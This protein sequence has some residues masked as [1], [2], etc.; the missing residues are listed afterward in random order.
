MVNYLLLRKL[1]AYG[2]KS[3][4][5][6][7]ELE[8]GPGITVVVG[9]NGSGKSN[10]SDAIR[11]A[12]GEQSVRNLRGAKLEDVIFA[13]STGRRPLGVAEVSLVFDNSDGGLPL[14]FN[15]VIITRR[16]FRSGDSEYFINKARC[17]LKDIYDLLSDTGLGRDA[18]PVI[19]QN[20]IDEVLNSKAEER[21]L[22]FEEAAGI[23]KYKQRKKEASRKLEDTAQ[24]LTR[25]SDITSE[26]ENQLEPLAESAARTARYNDLHKELTAYQV[27]LLMDKL[28]RAEK[29]VESANLQQQALADD[30]IAVNTQ[31]TLHETEL[32]RLNGQLDDINEKIT[33]AEAGSNKA[34]TDL[35][36]TDGKIGVLEE[37][38]KQ[39]ENTGERIAG[40]ICQAEARQAEVQNKASDLQNELEDKKR[41]ASTAHKELEVKIVEYQK[42]LT[43][44]Q[45]I[46]QQ[47][48][49][50]KDKTFAQL[51]E[52]VSERNK[53]STS[54]RD[55]A[56]LKMRQMNFDKE[57]QDYGRQLGEAELQYNNILEEKKTIQEVLIEL[58][59]KNETLLE[60]NKHVE[61]SLDNL[62]IE[63]KQL[64]NQLNE[65]TS[66]LNVLSGM[67]QELEGFS[68]GIKSILNSNKE[69]RQGI[70]GAVAQIITVPDKY[71]TAVEVALGGALQHIIT[72]D[73]QIA[74]NAIEF[75]KTQNLGRATFLPLNTIKVNRPRESEI[76]A[77]ATQGALG[78]ASQLVSCQERFRNVVDFLLGRTIVAEN[79]DV[80]LKIAKQNS[81]GI[82]LVT[83]E[84]EIV[85]PGGSM[86]GGSTARREAS[87]ISRTNE[88]AAGKRTID[89][90]QD[91][92][93]SHKKLRDNVEADLANIQQDLL[94]INQE[95]QSAQ[96]R[97]AELAVHAEKLQ[98][99]INRLTLATHTLT[100]EIAVAHQEQELLEKALS[101]LKTNITVLEERDND[102]KQ[103]I[104]KSQQQAKELQKNKDLLNDAVTEAKIVITALNQEITAITANSERYKQDEQQIHV[105]LKNL[106]AE[107][108]N[109]VAQ[110]ALSDQELQEL[111]I[112]RDKL[113]EEKLR[114]GEE[115]KTAY[116]EKMLLLS[117]IQKLEKEL[118]ELRRKY[119]DIQS[120]LHEAELISAKYG[121]EV[122]GC[123]EQLQ[124]QFDL[125]RE[126]AKDI[127]HPVSYEK[128]ATV[129]KRLED[130][131]AL[132]GPVNAIAIEEYA[133]VQERYQFL[134]QQYQ[135]L[136][137]ARDYLTSI[138]NDIDNNMS[139]QFAVAFKSIN[140]HFG[141]IFVRL[142]GGG[143]AQLQLI[144][145]D[146]VL[147]TGIDIIVQPPGKK[148]QNLILLSGGERALTVIALLFAFLT[149]RPVPFTMVDEI[150]AALDEANI[151]RFSEFLRDYAQNTQ[152]IVVTH[153]KAT[154]EV[155]DVLHGVTMEESGVSR[156]VSVKFMDKVG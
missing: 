15:E 154:M 93:S 18:M 116:A 34:S 105:Y 148:Q 141:D 31:T 63:E 133:R 27:T 39:G 5:D 155:A 60:H 122:T 151:Q 73:D 53:L 32:E 90:I 107:K 56:K 30:E 20:K 17:R 109:A 64:S 74:K 118:K 57:Y 8:F 54:E 52:L 23:T 78:F 61:Q 50:G 29:M 108:D 120:R 142:F 25:V 9:P 96:V 137:E 75:L 41:Q 92:L 98:A 35:E 72:Q 28:S 104:T 26:I 69:W 149:Y 91:K 45:Q 85:N 12:L 76:S 11:W 129:I 22:L 99:E 19:G 2:F 66:K 134:Q 80:A 70:C 10:I 140:E 51:Q 87:F 42:T 36:R 146:N 16:V 145:P 94:L 67:Q 102:F 38:I 44:I 33:L 79:I 68:R 71:V 127:C 14:D 130:E 86:T 65:L 77:A 43:S 121:Y 21:R 103:Q 126:E 81:F 4:A 88:I 7:T 136:I 55:L 89:E 131:I 100:E 106:I 112:A 135:D 117:G 46:E 82:K 47:I 113:A 3:F 84:G 83:L 111:I 6:K 59:S 110:V 37:R 40:Q 125:G 114:Y 156:L 119:N 24:N 144:E 152:F 95:R 143:K 101:D 128:A 124:E 1:E 153:R 147:E 132:L 115:Y 62:I 58:D 48:E 150:D 138:I 49:L 97:Q 123:Q 13:G 139:R